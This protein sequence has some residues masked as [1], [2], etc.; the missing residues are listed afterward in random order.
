MFENTV[1]LV[2]NLTA[3]PELRFTRSSLPVAS[4]TVAVTERRAAEGGQQ[5]EYTAFVRCSV[6]R[7]LAENVAESL[8]KGQRV[9]V[10]VDARDGEIVVDGWKTSTGLDLLETSGALEPFVGELLLPVL[11]GKAP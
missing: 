4:F 9:I 10:A 7:A 3:D 8:R 5:K 1:M 11:S 2:G 6:W